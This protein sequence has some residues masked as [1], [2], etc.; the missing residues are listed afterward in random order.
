MHLL[1]LTMDILFTKI[2]S[3]DGDLDQPELLGAC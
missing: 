1:I 2:A 3:F